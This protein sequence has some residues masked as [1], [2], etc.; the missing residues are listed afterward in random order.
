VW[1][2]P[3]APA[4]VERKHRRAFDAKPR[5]R[6]KNLPLWARKTEASKGKS[7][8]RSRKTTVRSFCVCSGCDTCA[9]CLVY[10]ARGAV[11]NFEPQLIQDSGPPSRKTRGSSGPSTPSR[12][13]R[14]RSDRDTYRSG[15]R[16]VPRGRDKDKDTDADKKTTK[17]EVGILCLRREF[18]TPALLYFRALVPTPYI[19]LLAH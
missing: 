1:P 11:W 8:V 2:P 7:R 19:F 18:H 4:P 3:T 16:A 14:G 12:G 5:E 6:S 15:G 9:V 10:A 13:V 17:D